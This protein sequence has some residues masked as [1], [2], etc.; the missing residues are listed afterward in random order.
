MIV[1]RKL[2]RDHARRVVD[3]G[4][5]YLVGTNKGAAIVERHYQLV[6]S[7]AGDALPCR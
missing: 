5:R 7:A 3:R 2:V 6:S 1:R 4:T